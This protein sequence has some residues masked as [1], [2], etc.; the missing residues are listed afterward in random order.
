MAG[1][2][3]A[4]PSESV[5]RPSAY[6]IDG[7]TLGWPR[8]LQQDS[9]VDPV[10]AVRYLLVALSAVVTGCQVTPQLIETTPPT[11]YFT[12]WYENATHNSNFDE[13]APVTALSQDAN[14]CI[15]VASPF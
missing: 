10:R 8:I 1:R 14:K 2:A 12:V 15:F 9:R 13:V 11:L 6:L 5:F 7:M 4:W 3:P